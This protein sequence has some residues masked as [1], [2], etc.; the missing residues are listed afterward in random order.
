MAA[1][2]I[3]HTLVKK[4]ISP[5]N[6]PGPIRAEWC[7]VLPH[8][9]RQCLTKTHVSHTADSATAESATEATSTC[10]MARWM[11][12]VWRTGNMMLYVAPVPSVERR[13]TVP[14]KLTM[15]SWAETP[16]ESGYKLGQ[17]I[18]F[19]ILMIGQLA[20]GRAKLRWSRLIYPSVICF[21]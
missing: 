16:Q 6:S 10:C 20:N 3:G 8:G 13:L 19:K 12:P 1:C 7:L 17:S 11:W 9:Q 21:L 14:P 4:N 2:L 5:V 15:L 18:M